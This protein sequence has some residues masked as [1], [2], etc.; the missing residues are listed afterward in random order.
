MTSDA[1]YVDG[2]RSKWMNC[3]FRTSFV[4][5]EFTVQAVLPCHNFPCYVNFEKYIKYISVEQ[6]DWLFDLCEQSKPSLASSSQG[7]CGATP[8][9]PLAQSDTLAISALTPFT[10]S[11]VTCWCYV[12]LFPLVMLHALSSCQVE[13]CQLDDYL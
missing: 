13:T 5:T 8:K 10:F 11:G 7:I 3:K 12:R 1:L 9:A 6:R 2:P 4:H